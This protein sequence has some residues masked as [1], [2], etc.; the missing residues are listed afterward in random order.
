MGCLYSLVLARGLFLKRFPPLV[1]SCIVQCYE[2]AGIML[3][4]GICLL[5]VSVI[6][7]PTHFFHP[8]VSNSHLLIRYLVQCALV[9]ERCA[10]PMQKCNENFSDSSELPLLSL[11]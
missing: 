11:Q 9:T 6:E 1:D 3:G 8:K 2:L 4:L 5:F 10:N 7:F